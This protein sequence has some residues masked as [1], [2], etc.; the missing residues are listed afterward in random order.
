MARPSKKT[1]AICDEIVRRLRRGETL[2]RMCADNPHLPHRDTVDDWADQDAEFS[3]QIARARQI[4]S[5]ALIEENRDIA[6]DGSND[7]MERFDKDGASLGYFLNG[8]AVSR[9]KLRIASSVWPMAA[10]TR[11]MP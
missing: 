1:K 6:D 3:G 11:P 2:R 5:H 9:S 7:Y 10:W 4:G 8:E